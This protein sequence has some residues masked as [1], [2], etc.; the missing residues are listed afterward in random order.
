MPAADL[1]YQLLIVDDEELVR[2]FVDRI[3]RSAGY[4]TTLA[5]AGPAAL[6]L[7]STSPAFDLLLTDLM[8]PNMRGD[9]LVRRMRV[10]FPD[11]KVLYL[12]AFADSLF[13]T[14]PLLWDNETFVEK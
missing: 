8:M 14:R 5:A 13:Q 3:L 2:H 9:E 4:R 12:T 10:A 11:L 1:Q 7:A 6:E